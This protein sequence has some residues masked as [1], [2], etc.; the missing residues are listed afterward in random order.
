MWSNRYNEVVNEAK[1]WF[2]GKQRLKW[3]LGAT[4]KHCTT[5]QALDGIVA[6]ASEWEQSGLKPQN[7]PNPNLECGGWHCD[8]S[9]ETTDEKR[10]PDALG[11]LMDLATAAHT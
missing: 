2:G 11:T 7:P 6:Y 4:E 10:S 3:K 8:C 5:C 1:I 9:L